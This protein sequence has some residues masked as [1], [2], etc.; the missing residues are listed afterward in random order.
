MV[1][2]ISRRQ[3]DSWSR[4]SSGAD[5]RPRVSGEHQ[6]TGM[7]SKGVGS[8]QK[9]CP[10]TC[11]PIF[12]PYRWHSSPTTKRR[13]SCLQRLSR[14]RLQS[15]DLKTGRGATDREGTVQSPVSRPR[16][17]KGRV[18]SLQ[19]STQGEEKPTKGRQCSLQ[20]PDLHAGG[21]ATYRGGTVQSPVSRSPDLSLIH[22]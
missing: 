1:S 2:K 14:G 9:R 18:S 22:I 7:L 16:Q 15:P 12:H 5:S 8:R 20:S 6:G 17:T 10:V 13:K 21:G 4:V 11:H 3:L 19:I